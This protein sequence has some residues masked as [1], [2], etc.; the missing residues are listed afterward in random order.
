MT[1]SRRRR[2]RTAWIAWCSPLDGKVVIPVDMATVLCKIAGLGG[3]PASR[4]RQTR[5]SAGQKRRRWARCSAPPPWK[6][7]PSAT[8]CAVRERPGDAERPAENA[9]GGFCRDVWSG[10]AFAT[11]RRG[12][13]AS[14]Q[15]DDA[16]PQLGRRRPRSRNRIGSGATTARLR[17][18]LVTS[19]GGMIWFRV[20]PA[21]SSS[22]RSIDS[23]SVL[24]SRAPG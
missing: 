13:T 5:R 19:R 16:A 20:S 14:P 22:R 8:A 3:L 1:R 9:A 12:R 4:R 23:A 2:W 18:F 10:S 21:P 15:Q 11:G 7:M 24:P 6:I 17:H